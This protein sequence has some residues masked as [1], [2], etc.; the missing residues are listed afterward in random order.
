MTYDTDKFVIQAHSVHYIISGMVMSPGWA[1]TYLIE[2]VQMD[3]NDAAE[4]LY[5]LRQKELEGET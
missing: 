4:Y 1:R 3:E 2:N 5:L